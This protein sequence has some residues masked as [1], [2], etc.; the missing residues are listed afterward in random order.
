MKNLKPIKW[1]NPG[2][3]VNWW[4]GDTLLWRYYIDNRDGWY[5]CA[6]KIHKEINRFR[7]LADAKACCEAHYAAVVASLFD[8]AAPTTKGTQ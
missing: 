1:R 2:P 6:T 8:D 5:T 7:S 4:Y 3:I